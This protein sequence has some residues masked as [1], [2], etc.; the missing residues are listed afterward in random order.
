[1]RTAGGWTEDIIDRQVT[2]RVSGVFAEDKGVFARRQASTWSQRVPDS[3]S[4]SE[5][6][7]GEWVSSG[8]A[9]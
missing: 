9:T 6:T 1:L 2:K 3:S 8:K 4:A 7:G 5:V